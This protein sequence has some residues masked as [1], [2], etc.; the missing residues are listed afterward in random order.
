MSKNGK[1]IHG[2]LT[3]PRQHE[4]KFFW[5]AEKEIH[6]TPAKPLK[7]ACFRKSKRGKS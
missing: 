5:Y 7:E 1:V 4:M 3:F 2:R 6:L